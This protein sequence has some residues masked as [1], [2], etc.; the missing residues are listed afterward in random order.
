M[1]IHRRSERVIVEFRVKKIHF[2]VVA[3]PRIPVVRRST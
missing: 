3:A 1:P 2:T